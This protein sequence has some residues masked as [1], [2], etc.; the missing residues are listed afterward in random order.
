MS[1]RNLEKGKI[2]IFQSVKNEKELKLLIR[3]NVNKDFWK[4]R[5]YPESQIKKEKANPFYNRI[6]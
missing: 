6:L 4:W 1:I 2:K 5:F 3:S